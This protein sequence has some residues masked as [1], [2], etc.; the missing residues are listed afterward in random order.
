MGLT[1]R[2]GEILTLYY[3]VIDNNNSYIIVRFGNVF[4]SSGSLIPSIIKQINLYN[5]VKITDINVKRY[6]MLPTEAAKLIIFSLINTNSSD[7]SVLDMGESINI[8]E[9]TKKIIELLNYNKNIPI[10]IIGLR[11]GEKLTEE[12]IYAYESIREKKQFIFII[13]NNL[14]IKENLSKIQEFIN[15]IKSYDL[16]LNNIE[17]LEKILWNFIKELEPEEL[18]PI[19]ISKKN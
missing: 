1:K 13:D 14:L 17:E 5:K 16:N 6:F 15:F 2:I 9:L 8:F 12:L 10:E 18:K 4:G 3:S 11:K 19:E 7:I